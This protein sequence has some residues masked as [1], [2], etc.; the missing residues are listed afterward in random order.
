MRR[1]TLAVLV[2]LLA[3]PA[4]RACAQGR[5]AFTLKQPGASPVYGRV[6]GNLSDYSWGLGG[7]RRGGDAGGLLQSSISSTPNFSVRRSRE[8]GSSAGPQLSGGSLLGNSPGVTGYSSLPNLGE[9][10]PG[11]RMAITPI[12]DLRAYQAAMEGGGELAADDKP[13]TSWVPSEPS[14]YQ[15]HMKRGEEAFR[16]GRWLEAVGSFE[17][18]ADLARYAPEPHLALLHAHFASGNYYSAAYQL[19]DGLKYFPQLPLAR[20]QVRRF[21]GETRDFVGHVERLQE[22]TR[23]MTVTADLWL[24]LAYFRYFDEAQADAIQALRECLAL[25]PSPA[26]LEAIQIF[27]DGMVAAGKAEGDLVAATQPGATTAPAW[28]VSTSRHPSLL[29]ATSLPAMPRPAATPRPVTWPA[30]GH[31]SAGS[32]PAPSPASRPAQPAAGPVAK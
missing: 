27:W 2:L 19:R 32:A 22:R 24:V 17:V 29:P 21:Y 12:V 26:S 18:A 15:T 5:S 14:L 20:L 6:G 7:L 3:W 30:E 11:A 9:M 10:A 28:R 8:E 1:S 23:S 4:G 13:I 31:S 16:Q 25:N